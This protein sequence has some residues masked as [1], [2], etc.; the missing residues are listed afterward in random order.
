MIDTINPGSQVWRFIYTWGFLRERTSSEENICRLWWSFLWGVTKFGAFAT[1]IAM[2]FYGVVLLAPIMFFVEVIELDYFGD[3]FFSLMVMFST[4]M[5]IIIWA[6]AA[7]LGVTFLLFVM[8]AGLRE[9]GVTEKVAETS[10]NMGVTGLFSTW[11]TA[12]KEKWC[13]NVKIGDK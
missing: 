2:A 11:W 7:F 5:G 8:A 4:L 1:A 6:G 9:L 10:R 12:H 13:F 3:G